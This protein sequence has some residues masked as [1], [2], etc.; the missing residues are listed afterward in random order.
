MFPS[1]N[2][3]VTKTG[4]MRDLLYKNPF[5]CDMDFTYFKATD[6]FLITPLTAFNR[7]I[8]FKVDE[9]D[10]LLDSS[11]M[12]SEDWVTIA[13]RIEKAYDDYDSFIILHGT[14]TMAYTASALSFMF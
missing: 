12:T 7:R 6:D 13:E 11:N 2:G 10:K 4:A 5:A 14:D 3:Y 8:W 1:E 9:L